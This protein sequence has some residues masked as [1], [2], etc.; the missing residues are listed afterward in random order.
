VTRVV[1]LLPAGTEIVAALGDAGVLAG[2]THECDFPAAVRSLPRVTSSAVDAAADPGVV[3][4]SVRELSAAG[5]PLFA[6]DAARVAELRPEVILTQ[7]VCEVCAVSESDVRALA[8]CLTPAPCVVTLSA[9]T[10]DGVFDDIRCVA[11]ALGTAAAGDALVHGL[12]GRLRQVHET[13]KGARA[14]RPRVAVIEW[15]DPVYAAG[16]WVPEMVRRAGGVDVLARDG[17]HSRR[18]TPEQVAASD[19]EVLVVAPCGYDVARAAD[20]ARRL[21]GADEWAWARSHLVWA[22]DGN[23]LLSRPGPRLVEGVE[24]L[25]AALHP[26]HFPPPPDTSARA[27]P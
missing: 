6:I 7:A 9:S 25:A 10:L 14:P 20:E 12:R 21:L 27:L 11:A 15:T 22:L 2:V 13:L 18:V 8:E 5:A 19:P 17:E 26:A 24:V 4:A 16:H 3:D 1:S 23:A